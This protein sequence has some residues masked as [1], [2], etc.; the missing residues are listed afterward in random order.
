MFFSIAQKPQTNFSHFYHLGPFVI[1]TDAGWKRHDA[2]TYSCIYKGYA[3]SGRL[4]D[5][6]DQI[7]NQTEPELFGSFCVI[8]YNNDTRAL[9][10]KTDRLRGFP[11]YFEQRVGA[12]NL[13]PIVGLG[14]E[15][16]ISMA[17]ADSLLTVGN[18]LSIVEEKFNVIGALDDTPVGLEEIIEFVDQRLNEKAKNFVK[19]NTLPINVFLS[20]GVDTALVYSYLQKYTKEFELVKGNIFEYDRFWLQNST[21]ITDRYWGYKQIHHW[22]APCVL[23]SGAPGDEFM[24][25]S[26][27]YAD[28]Y[29]KYYG[30]EIT[31]LLKERTW[32]HTAYFNEPKHIKLFETQTVNQQ[33]PKKQLQWNLCNNAVNDWQHWHVG[34]TLTWTPLRDLEIYKMFLRLEPEV[35]IGQVMDSQISLNLIERNCPGLSSIISD[36]KNSG[37]YL[38]NLAD[39][40]LGPV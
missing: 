30:V 10:I 40:L 33:M 17:W 3:D 36:Q 8:V 25:R 26:P 28:Q 34:N 22:L 21:D 39:Y 24:L 14:L 19:F 20:G 1:S 6:L 11:L 27:T 37:N 31:D 32:L 13:K 2:D 18:D 7:A 15:P 5:L 35:A 12:T 29:L 9:Q 4:V 23:T 16:K 38:K